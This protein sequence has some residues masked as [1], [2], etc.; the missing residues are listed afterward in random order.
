[1]T[2]R[3][4]CHHRIPGSHRSA[5]LRC[6]TTIELLVVVIL[7]VILLLPI[8]N[9][10]RSGRRASLQ[11]MTQIDTSLEGRRIL[12]QVR[13]D[14]KQSCYLLFK[15]SPRVDFSFML[16]VEPKDAPHHSFSFLTFPTIGELSDFVPSLA[17][18]LNT[19]EAFRRVSRITYSLESLGDPRKSLFRLIRE[20]KFHAATIASGSYPNG[21]RRQILSTRVNFFSIRPHVV[22]HGTEKQYFFW[23]AVQVVDSGGQREVPFTVGTKLTGKIPGFQVADFFDVVK[24]DF[25]HSVWNQ[26][27]MR[28]NWHSFLEGP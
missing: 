2:S 10:Y 7:I 5:F 9:I 20:E 8:W 17:Q 14:L 23:V 12:K 28:R 16:K 24:S 13:R 25:F 1:M 27:G 21:V 19:G 18:P 3:F 6:F 4:P 22:Q 26:E 15:E 11:G